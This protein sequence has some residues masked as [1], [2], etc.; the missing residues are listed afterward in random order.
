MKLPTAQAHTSTGEF[1]SIESPHSVLMRTWLGVK[2]GGLFKKATGR[3]DF[4]THAFGLFGIMDLG[5][6]QVR[7]S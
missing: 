3:I 6:V 7:F 2:R 1:V 4:R 5:L